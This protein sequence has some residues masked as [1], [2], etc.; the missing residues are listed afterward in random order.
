MQDFFTG[1]RIGG[2]GQRHTRHRRKALG[3]HAQLAVFRAEVMPPLRHAMRFVD[4]EQRQI[5]AI[6]KF[7]KARRQ[8]SLGRH[9]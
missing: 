9:I 8:Q 5:Q 7:Q 6:Q 2:G 3:Q 1:L 4:G